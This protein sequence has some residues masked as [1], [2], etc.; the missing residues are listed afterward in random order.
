MFAFLLVTLL[1]TSLHAVVIANPGSNDANGTT[2][3][4]NPGWAYVD[5]GGGSSCV[6]LGNGWVLTC[7]HVAYWA[8]QSGYVYVN[9]TKYDIATLP[10]NTTQDFVDLHEPGN[11]NLIDLTLLH[12]AV[13][14]ANPITLPSFPIASV[15]PTAG[16]NVMGIGFGYDQQTSITYWN[17]SWAEVTSSSS[18]HSG[19]KLNTSA[20]FKRWGTN[21]ISASAIYDDPITHTVNGGYGNGHVLYTVFNNNA[22]GSEFQAVPHDSGGGLF[23]QDAN[24]IW[25]LAGIIELVDGQRPNQPA[26]TVLFR[27]STSVYTGNTMSLDLS[28][29]RDQIVAKV[30]TFQISSELTNPAPYIGSGWQSVQLIGNAGFTVSSGNWNSIPIDTNGHTFSLK[31]G[32][33]SYEI[34][35]V[36]SGSGGIVKSEAGTLSLT[37]SNTYSGITSIAEGY[38]Q[39]ADGIGLPSA[40]LLQLD[41]GVFQSIASTPTAF[42][43]S[44][45]TTG[46]SVAWSLAG[47]GFSAG[48]QPQSSMIVNLGGGIPLS[49]SSSSADFGSKLLGAL[50]LG[51]SNAAS[52]TLVGNDID[53][54]G[55]IRTVQVEDNT[56]SA[57]DYAVFSGVLS[58]SSA[59]S[60]GLKKTGD[61][62]LYLTNVNTYDGP[63]QIDS[64]ILALSQLGQ[65]SESSPIVNNATFWIADDITTHAVGSISGNGTTYVAD[66]ATLYAASIVQDTLVIGGSP[67]LVGAASFAAV[68][69]PATWLLL[70]IGLVAAETI[71]RIRRGK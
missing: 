9:N 6:Y 30:Q 18:V 53:L 59:T 29:Y 36:V 27:D 65:I 13:D 48:T 68:P 51:S 43:R 31:T 4:G 2:A 22:D 15:A 54:N 25:Q 69:E 19:F 60:A 37:N 20:A 11:S 34:G 66:G 17:S 61:G 49:W 57:A 16:T 44:L 56:S 1:A 71:R 63:T 35:V 26:N 70:A 21:T 33:G 64:G 32:G 41:G 23:Y 45:G 55:A 58:N 8:K 62:L 12:L 38:L 24:G 67:S 42:T 14:P 39:A 3:P 28:Y 52:F 7:R 50:K 10:D 46:G 40:S 5:R 47:G